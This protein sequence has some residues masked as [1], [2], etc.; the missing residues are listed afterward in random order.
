MGFAPVVCPTT[1][2]LERLFYPTASGI[3]YAAYSLVRGPDRSWA[4]NHVEAPEIFEFK[5]PF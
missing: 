2:K 5:G 1:R 4:P 3:A